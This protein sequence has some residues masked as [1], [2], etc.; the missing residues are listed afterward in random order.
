[1]TYRA[2]LM[3]SEHQDAVVRIWKENMSDPEI[4]KVA[5]DRLRWFYDENPTGRPR[6]MVAVVEETQEVVGCGSTFARKLWASGRALTAGI[7][8]DFAVTRRHR[9]GGAAVCIQR[10]LVTTCREAGLSC[11]VGFPNARAYKVLERIGYQVI[12][13]AR[14]WVKPLRTAKKIEARIGRPPVARALGAVVDLG[15]GAVDR[16]RTLLPR[17]LVGE[18]LDHPDARFDALWEEARGNYRIVGEKTREFLDWR[19]ARFKSVRYRFFALA[20]RASG[21]LVGWTAFCVKDGV[22]LLEDMFAR[23]MEVSA[24]RVLLHFS[25]AMRAAGHASIY[26]GFVGREAFAQRLPRLGFFPSEDQGRSLVAWVDPGEAD[27]WK[28]AVVDRE[29]WFMFSGEMDI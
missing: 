12:G 23:D 2:V 17:G 8:A 16:A 27:E 6:T 28:R 10:A 24:D 4:A 9:I 25:T 11:I 18:V 14:A 22:V 19:Y 26:V 21:R 5:D 13:V 29:S 3:G 7:P 1:M 15:L 20:E